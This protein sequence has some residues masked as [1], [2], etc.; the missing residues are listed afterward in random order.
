MTDVEVLAHWDANFLVVRIGRDRF[1]GI[2]SYDDK[3]AAKE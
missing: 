3:D 2:N 1:R